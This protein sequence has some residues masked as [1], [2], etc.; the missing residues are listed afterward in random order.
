MGGIIADENSG[1]VVR[2]IEGTVK[3]MRWNIRNGAFVL[4]FATD[5]VVFD[6]NGKYKRLEIVWLDVPIA[7][8]ASTSE[9]A[10]H[11]HITDVTTKSDQ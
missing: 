8:D 7:D 9:P 10:K 3:S 2:N 4:Q 11:R 6:G 5:A 1:E